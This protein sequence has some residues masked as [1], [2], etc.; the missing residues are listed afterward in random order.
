MPV[1]DLALSPATRIIDRMKPTLQGR[2]VAILVDE[3]SNAESIAALRKALTA[4]KATVKIIAPKIG[5]ATLSDGT[6]L[7][8]DGQLAGS[9]SAQFDAVAS[10]LPLA[11]GERLAK[12]AAAQ[13]WFRDAFGHLKAIAACKGTHLILAA[14][15]VTPD[16]GVFAPEDV[17]QFVQGAQQRFWD[18]EPTLRTLA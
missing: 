1:Q 2:C 15:G 18:R 9:P 13:D 4:A 7:A 10:V 3:G 11:C 17:K 12:E 5:G 6:H 14:A 8:A 16:A